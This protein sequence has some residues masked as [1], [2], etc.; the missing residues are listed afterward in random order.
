MASG[1]VVR[2]DAHGDAR[3]YALSLSPA[4]ERMLKCAAAPRRRPRSLR[5]CCTSPRTSVT[6]FEPCCTSSS[7]AGTR[8][9][10]GPGAGAGDRG[11][12]ACVICKCPLLFALFGT[13][14]EGVL[15]LHLPRHT[16]RW[17][18]IGCLAGSIGRTDTDRRTGTSAEGAPSRTD[19][20][21]Q[22]QRGGLHRREARHGRFQL[23]TMGDPVRR[24]TLS[25]PTWDGRDG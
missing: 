5:R 2:R 25:A 12:S 15:M 7:T 9:P 3:S 24:V 21:D 14:D 16:M 18:V 22:H 8:R 23:E 11:R 20:A 17:S 19:E 6:T 4:G 13:R 1:L 10:P